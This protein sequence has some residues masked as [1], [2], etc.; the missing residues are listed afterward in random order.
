MNETKYVTLCTSPAP[1]RS[2]TISDQRQRRSAEKLGSDTKIE[3]IFSE[4]A[5]IQKVGLVD[6]VF[7]IQWRKKGPMY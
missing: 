1:T 2:T 7:S 3:R 6:F 4:H 5:S